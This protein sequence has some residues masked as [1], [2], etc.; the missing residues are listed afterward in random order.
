LL[1]REFKESLGKAQ[2]DIEPRPPAFLMHRGKRSRLSRACGPNDQDQLVI[3]VPDA[4]ND[5]TSMILE[6]REVLIPTPRQ[7]RRRSLSAA[8]GRDPHA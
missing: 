5:I 4:R 3:L 2:I 6:A 7:N 8:T 1:L